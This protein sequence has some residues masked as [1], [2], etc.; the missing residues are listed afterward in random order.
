MFC[1]FNSFTHVCLSL[2]HTNKIIGYGYKHTKRQMR[3][4]EEEE[5]KRK[6]SMSVNYRTSFCVCLCLCICVCVAW[7]SPV[8]FRWQLA[9][10]SCGGLTALTG[11]LPPQPAPGERPCDGER[12]TVAGGWQNGL[13]YSGKHSL[14]SLKQI[15]SSKWVEGKEKVSPQPTSLTLCHELS[16][17]VERLYNVFTTGT[18]W[19]RWTPEPK[20]I[21]SSCLDFG[22]IQFKLYIFLLS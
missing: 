13:T 16:W 2:S 20:S 4:T 11:R 1:Y 5:E 17:R 10:H 7:D 21:F 14:K 18:F 3:Q 19:W 15:R 6:L 8:G 22:Y 9:C 12:V